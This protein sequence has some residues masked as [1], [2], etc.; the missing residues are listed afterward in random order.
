MRSQA[1]S[2]VADIH[3]F[4]VMYAIRAWMRHFALHV[5]YFKYIVE[6]K[7]LIA[8]RS[9]GKREL[10]QQHELEEQGAVGEQRN[11]DEI[12]LLDPTAREIISFQ[13]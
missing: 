7:R 3:V 1:A 11:P 13:V 12:S 4:A 5:C 6:T 9:A 8:E 10:L 2:K